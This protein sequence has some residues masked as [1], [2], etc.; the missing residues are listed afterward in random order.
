MDRADFKSPKVETV[1]DHEQK[2]KHL[3]LEKD[4]QIR[5][6]KTMENKFKTMVDFGDDEYKSI[7]CG[8]GTALKDQFEAMRR[9]VYVKS[10]FFFEQKILIQCLLESHPK[11]YYVYS[12]AWSLPTLVLQH[13]KSRIIISSL[14]SLHV[15]LIFSVAKF[16]KPMSSY[17]GLGDVETVF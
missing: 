14:L 11:E 9:P 5:C 10:S 6:M 16:C 7:L 8:D 3:L 13:W 2:K 12:I 15:V 17:T 4:F 1:L